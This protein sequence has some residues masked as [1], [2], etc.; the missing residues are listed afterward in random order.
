MARVHLPS[1]DGDVQVQ[2]FSEVGESMLKVPDLFLAPDT[3]KRFPQ[4]LPFS[5]VALDF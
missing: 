3:S 4:A 5:L 2:L 1:F